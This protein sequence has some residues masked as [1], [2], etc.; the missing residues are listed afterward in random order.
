MEALVIHSLVD[1]PFLSK[2]T[3]G[4]GVFVGVLTR[5]LIK[6]GYSVTLPVAKLYIP[7]KDVDVNVIPT[8]FGN[9]RFIDE[10]DLNK[11]SVIFVTNI[12]STFMMFDYRKLLESPVPKILEIEDHPRLYKLLPEV[13]Q[14]PNVV[15][16]AD[17][18]SIFR[19]YNV[20]GVVMPLLH[21]FYNDQIRQ[22]E[23]DKFYHLGR[24][25]RDKKSD[26]LANFPWVDVYGRF[27][28]NWN[29]EIPN[30]KGSASANEFYR[31]LGYK[32]QGYVRVNG[33]EWGLQYASIEAMIM[34]RPVIVTT[35][36]EIEDEE[37][38]YNKFSLRTRDYDEALEFSQS[39]NHEEIREYAMTK[40][41]SHKILENL[42][43]SM[44]R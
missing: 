15:I 14:Y 3:G 1:N 25:C 43:S 8:R 2:P 39:V 38:A 12:H 22:P 13:V 17:R 19:K 23:L 41:V 11:F 28:S 9:L 44:V 24:L 16:V 33:T 6:M 42:V 5:K 36:E 29:R 35:D 37:W 10:M 18:P 7:Y 20:D 40:F 4:I 30:Y 26:R 21:D 27:C 34:G 32:Y 31:E